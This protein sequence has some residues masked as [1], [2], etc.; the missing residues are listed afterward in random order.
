MKIE[1]AS[2]R[3]AFFVGFGFLLVSNAFADFPGQFVVTNW[4]I[5]TQAFGCGASSVDTSGAPASVALS[6]GSGCASIGASFT[7]PSAPS[8]GVVAFSYAYSVGGDGPSDYPASYVVNGN[9][10]AILEQ[11]RHDLAERQFDLLRRAR[12]VVRFPLSSGK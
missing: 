8:A 4:T 10:D 1:S 7:F 3:I 12:S 6:T 11:C 2:S 9:A 5:S